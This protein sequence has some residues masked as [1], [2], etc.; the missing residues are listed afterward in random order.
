MRY[1]D[2]ILPVRRPTPRKAC[3][4]ASSSRHYTSPLHLT[5]EC[6][7]WLLVSYIHHGPLSCH[8]LLT[9]IFLPEY[10]CFLFLVCANAMWP[11]WQVG[12]E[13]GC[14]GVPSCEPPVLC[15]TAH[16]DLGGREC[17][18]DRGN[19]E[20]APIHPP[21]QPKKKDSQVSFMS[22]EQR[23]APERGRSLS[24]MGFRTKLCPS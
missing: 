22:R 18:A 11:F 14:S 13:Q 5:K 2:D 7:C 12:K 8:Q 15:I 1:P 24:K 9:P 10:I 23:S 19:R 3:S 16:N 17:I 21:S 6:P 20:A 4:S